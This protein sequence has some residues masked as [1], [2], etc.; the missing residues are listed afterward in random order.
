MNLTAIVL[1][2]LTFVSTLFGG[3][4]ALRFRDR[5][6]LVMGF[7]A[8]VI[9]GVWP[10]QSGEPVL[11]NCSAGVGGAS[12]PPANGGSY[13]VGA[14]AP[15]ASQEIEIQF[16]VGNIPN[17]YTAQAYVIFGCDQSDYAWQN[18]LTG[19]VIGSI[20]FGYLV[21][22]DAWFETVAGDVCSRG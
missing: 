15:G 16:N 10:G 17:S 21:K 12:S 8:G 13:S 22:V 19:N 7:A 1:S 9:L 14:L 2:A 4:L 20:S 18:N 3:F 6:H 11:P 5:L